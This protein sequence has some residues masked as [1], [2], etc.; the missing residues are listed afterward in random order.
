MRKRRFYF[1]DVF[2][3]SALFMGFNFVLTLILA[4]FLQGATFSKD[5]L[6]VFN[7]RALGPY[8]IGSWIS[9][10]AAP[11]TNFSKYKYTFYV[12]A[13]NGGVWK[14]ENNG[15]TFYPIFDKYGSLSIGAIAVDQRNPEIVWVGTGESFNARLSHPGDG[16]YKS[17]DGGK[18]FVHLGL[19]ETHHISKIVIDPRNSNVV[20]VAAMG[21]LFTPNKERG[22]YKT[23]D[24]GKTWKKVFYINENIGVIDLVI[25]PKNPDILYAAAYEK[26]RYPWHFE[27]G[28]E[29]SGIYKTT[30]GGKTWKRLSGGLPHGKIGRIGLAIFPGN[31]DIVY[32]VVENLNP[33]PGAKFPETP[34]EYIKIKFNKMGDP[35]WKFIVGGE[36]YRTTDGGLHWEKRNSSKDNVSSKAAYSFNKI[37]VAPDDPNK[38]YILSETLEYS[39]DGGKTWHNL[40]WPQIDKFSNMFGDVRAMWIDPNDSRHMLIGSD[41][42]LYVTYDGG[43]TV[44]HLY[45]IPLGEIYA[46]EADNKIP[47]NIY[48]GLQDHEIWMGPS[49]SWRGEITI[50]DWFLVGKWDGMYCKVDPE[51]NRWA[52]TTTQFGGH[53][54]VDLLNGERVDIEPKREKGKPPYRFPWTPPI[55]ISPHNP[56]II[57][58]GAQ[59]LLMSLDRG[60]HWIEIS[61]DLTTD[62]PVKIA[63]KGHMMY[64]TI[65]TISESPLKPGLIWVGTDDGK[66]HVTKDFGKSWSDCTSAI[67]AMGC[68]ENYW[69]TRVF[70]SNHFPGRAYVTKSG[71]KF[72]DFRPFV[73]RT[74]DYGKTW[75]NITGNLPKASVNVIYEDR[76]NPNLLFVGTEK[77][78]YVSLNGGG[79]WLP[80]NNNMPHVPVMDLMIHP[81]ENDLIVGTY[82]RGAFITDI[83]PLQELKKDILDQDAYL[84]S[85]EPKPQ[86]NYSQRR[87]WGNFELMGDRPITTPNEPNGLA[88]Y[89]YF[90][91]TSKTPASIEIYN[92]QGKLMKKM[93][94]NHDK[95]LHK[96]YWDTARSKPGV[97]KVVL[98]VEGKVLTRYAKVTPRWKWPVN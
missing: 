43:K 55:L 9:C 76:K 53:Q 24:G 36:V 90:K 98:K 23:T 86:M 40:K 82:G 33:K 35:F 77:G 42:G 11:P 38:I 20:Y 4:S 60:D 66:V 12:G 5:L 80:F 13:R 65:A 95:G 52:Y 1:K 7:Y 63:G 81:R 92:F 29:G 87:F 27:A 85:I 74:D 89:Y 30:D 58:A 14:T 37:R 26:Y 16:I 79:S 71:F 32:A 96:I 28:G 94:I 18:T 39:E 88:I 34:Q 10:I 51:T 67:T 22:I 69:V 31:P 78:V 93:K 45:N 68:P 25:N 8:K 73:F 15:T 50:E 47:Y 62:D 97:Y 56:Q 64:C 3:L 21:H 84:F 2:L 57:Y 83:S 61:P 17:E 48:V 75:V 91:D 41:G 54:R 19:E 59:M 72:D 44:D 49:N 70:A 46:V 6:S